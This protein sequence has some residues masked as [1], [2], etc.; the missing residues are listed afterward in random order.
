MQVYRMWQMLSKQKYMSEVIQERNRLNVLFVANSLHMF[1][2]M[3]C[4][5][6]FTVVRNRTSVSCVTRRG[7]V[8]LEIKTLA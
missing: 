6:E 7:L 1:E 3:L 2:T 5:A 8:S 4:T